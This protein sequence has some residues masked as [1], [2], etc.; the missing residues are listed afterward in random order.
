MD[1][2]KVLLARPRGFCAGV[3]MAI[4]ALA[5]MVRVF[6]PPVYC[7]HEIVHNRL[8]VERFR[9]QGVI[10]VDSID[11]VPDG[12]PVML[13]AHGSAPEVVSAARDRGRFVVDA[14][15]PLVTK[16]HH[17]AR[18]RAGKGYT[19]LYV[20]H[21]GHDEAIGT[22]AEAP[23]AMRL[24]EHEH[25]V[26]HAQIEDPTK[27]AV[28][29]Q[30][31]LALGDWK[32]VV[33]RARARYPEL[34]TATRDD[35]CFATTNRQAALTAIASRADAVLVI[36]SANSSNTLALEKVARNVGCPLVQRINGVEELD[37]AALN[38]ARIVGVT[39][40]A[41]AP[42]DVVQA[43]IARLA[44][45]EGVEEV[46]V[47]DEEE[48]FPPPRTLR[49]VMPVLDAVAALATGGAPLAAA[50]LGGSFSA[51]RAINASDTLAALKG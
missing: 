27:V 31:T 18:V 1:V 25:D 8:V 33:E 17:E 5:W 35:L 39:A 47:T 10:F 21:A 13:S 44:P 2:E 4:K 43:V 6:D 29:A 9:S 34:W 16:V 37:E 28:L 36:G 15:C 45:R 23:A 42:E 12:A 49:E 20:G 14:V 50:A 7:Y 19:I 22:L 11:D 32:G 24:V 40:G 30:T 26:D 46:D 3:E 38:G 51:D 48:Y 41:S